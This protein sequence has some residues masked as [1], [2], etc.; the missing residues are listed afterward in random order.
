MGWIVWMVILGVLAG[1]VKYVSTRLN[2]FATQNPQ[3]SDSGLAHG[4]SFGLNI[5]TGAVVALMVFVTGLHSFHQIPFGH[6]GILT[7][8]GGIEGQV[9][10][11]LQTIPPWKNI[12]LAN[13]QVQ[14]L[15]FRGETHLTS[16]SKESQD[17]FVEATVN[18]KVSPEA[19]QNLY[20]NVGPEYVNILVVPRVKQN[21]KDET[22]KYTSV[23]IAP[24]RE[25]IRKAVRDRLE[26]ELSA[27]SIE[28]T[29]LLLDNVDFSP[30]FKKAIEDKQVATQDALREFERVQQRKNEADQ[31]FQVANGQARAV[32]ELARGQASANRQLTESLTPEVIQWQAV[33]KL[34]DKIQIALLPSGQGIIIDPAS[35]LGATPPRP[36][37]QP[38]R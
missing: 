2:R 1:A 17:V 14:G 6:V 35:L 5:I 13:V 21:F 33:Q 26:R 38:Q 36:A 30:A 11:G 18:F 12:M 31:A 10:E 8:F 9:G 34:A 29:D 37:Q 32:E 4:W 27:N 15:G 20:R 3:D 22:V 25:E 16:F 19:I 7:M 24:N 23:L 28:I